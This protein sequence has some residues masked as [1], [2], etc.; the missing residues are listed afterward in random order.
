M[1]TINKVS[2]NMKFDHGTDFINMRKKTFWD[3]Y[4]LKRYQGKGKHSVCLHRTFDGTLV[5]RNNLI[6]PL[7]NLFEKE[8]KACLVRRKQH[9]DQI[10]NICYP[11]KT[12]DLYLDY[13]ENCD[14]QGMTL[15]RLQYHFFYFEYEYVSSCR[16]KEHLV[17]FTAKRRNNKILFSFFI[18]KYQ[19]IA[20]RY[21]CFIL[22]GYK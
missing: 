10:I 12:S 17:Y 2:E 1:D 7:I 3:L 22:V 4:D 16:I 19:F 15:P 9:Q 8:F 14:E 18:A 20:K 6:K 11:D 5:L 21:N 13:L